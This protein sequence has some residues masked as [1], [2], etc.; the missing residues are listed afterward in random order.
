MEKRK[1]VEEDRI[2]RELIERQKVAE[3][4]ENVKAEVNDRKVKDRDAQVDDFKENVKNMNQGR[5]ER[6]Q[7]NHDMK[8]QIENDDDRGDSLIEPQLDNSVKIVTRASPRLA[9]GPA[10]GLRLVCFYL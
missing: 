3:T 2:L 9:T 10:T 8:K 1:K 6:N 7:K 4:K 5:L